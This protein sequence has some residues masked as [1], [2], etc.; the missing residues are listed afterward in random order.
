MEHAYF[1]VQCESIT[2]DMWCIDCR[3][4]NK[5]STRTKIEMFRRPYQKP[6]HT[7]ILKPKYGTNL[8]SINTIQQHQWNVAKLDSNT[9]VRILKVSYPQYIEYSPSKCVFVETRRL[10]DTFLSTVY[11]SYGKDNIDN[12]LSSLTYHWPDVL[13]TIVCDY[14]TTT[15]CK[16]RYA[17]V[18]KPISAEQENFQLPLIEDYVQTN[19]QKFLKNTY[20]ESIKSHPTSTRVLCAIGCTI[21]VAKIFANSR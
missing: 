18:G 2:R 20:P 7:L 12:I 5:T 19:V 15:F 14:A 16:I 9:A 8:H 21:L 4:E 3:K 13:S 1:C 11:C 10:Q 6:T 17:F